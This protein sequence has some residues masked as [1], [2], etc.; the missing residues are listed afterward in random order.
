MT[1]VK[2]AYLGHHKCATQFL[3]GVF[4]ALAGSIGM[5]VLGSH[6]P[7]K[8]PG[9]FEREPRFALQRTEFIEAVKAGSYDFLIH[10]NADRDLLH[11]MG[12]H[13]FRVVHVIRDPRD[14]VVSGYF[15]HLR[16]H[17]VSD[18]NP[19]LG[20]HRDRLRSLSREE[21]LLA[22]LDFCETYFERI[23]EW[24][25]GDQRILE[26]RFEDVVADGRAFFGRAM[27]WFGL[28]VLPGVGGYIRTWSAKMMS[29][30]RAGP[31]RPGGVSS[32]V[33]D[34]ELQRRSFERLAGRR[35]GS[36][37]PS[38]HYRKGMPG[39]WHNHFTRRVRDAFIERYG[40]LVVRLGYERSND[41]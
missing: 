24:P 28:P 31:R 4:R 34:R 23:G 12:G 40:D 32:I 39:D 14:I 38:S 7:S 36:A 37:D 16:S 9:G 2:L 30:L 13:E 11:N 41:W 27:G 29:R 17:P 19:W 15:S 1:S 6:L 35:R 22:E 10:I 33:L 21:G 25:Y 3:V 5:R 18:A 8:P 26:C 20:S